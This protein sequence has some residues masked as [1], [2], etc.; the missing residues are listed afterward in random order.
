M[1]YDELA[2]LFDEHDGEYGK[3]EKVSNPK[4]RRRDIHAMI[5]LNELSPGNGKVLCHAGHDIVW[6][7][8]GLSKLAETSISEEQV[9][10]LIRCGVHIDE[11]E[12]LGMFV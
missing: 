12:G 5:L 8:P 6:L 1:T 9:I 11:G 2:D 10:E 4:S 7:E 3:F